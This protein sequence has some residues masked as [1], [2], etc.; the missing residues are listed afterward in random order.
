MKLAPLS[1]S[2]TLKGGGWGRGSCRS[3]EEGDPHPAN[4]ARRPPP[5]QGKVTPFAL[6]RFRGELLALVDRL[7]DG[8]DHVEGSLRQ[9]VVLAVDQALE[10]LDGV[11]EVDELAGRA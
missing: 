9:V 4:F 1:H 3:L 11:G 10:A 6:R 7:L 5:F 2:L 8:A